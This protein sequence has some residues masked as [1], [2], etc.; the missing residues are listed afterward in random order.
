[1]C[2]DFLYY[3]LSEAFLILRII[4]R[5]KK[6]VHKSSRKVPVILQ[7]STQL[8]FSRQIFEIKKQSNIKCH[9]NPSS[10]SRDV[11]CELT[12]TH[13]TQT[14]KPHTAIPRLTS[15]PANEFFG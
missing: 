4:Q 1:M 3:F 8:E 10:G 13:H 5:D 6:S 7:I 15:D 11:P 2:F 12:D 9:E 14:H